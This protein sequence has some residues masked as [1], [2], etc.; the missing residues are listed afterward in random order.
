MTCLLFFYLHVSSPSVKKDGTPDKRV[1]SEHG[2]GGKG[3]YTLP[4]SATRIDL[5]PLQT[6]PT[7]TSKV[8]RAA[9]PPA[10]PRRSSKSLAFS[11]DNTIGII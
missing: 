3:K 6:D 10:L 2:F 1:S 4:S 7:P 9:S 5:D 8:P 11:T